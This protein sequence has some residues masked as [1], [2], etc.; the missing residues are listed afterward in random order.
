MFACT[1]SNI[2]NTIKEMLEP[3]CFHVMKLQELPLD[4]IFGWMVSG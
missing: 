1:L 2:Q 3:F 4:L